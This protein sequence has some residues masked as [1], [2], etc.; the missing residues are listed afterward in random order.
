MSLPAARVSASA[1]QSR[2]RAIF[3][4]VCQSRAQ[5]ERK[6]TNKSRVPIVVRGHGK[7]RFPASPVP[8]VVRGSSKKK[9]EN[10]QARRGMGGGQGPYLHEQDFGRTMRELK[11]KENVQLKGG[12][13]GRHAATT[14]GILR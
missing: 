4:N 3:S 8:S 6:C 11:K 14:T 13:G 5:K 1:R 7:I 12:M 2:E 10:I 9:K